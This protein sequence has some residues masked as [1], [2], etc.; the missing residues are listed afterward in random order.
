MTTGFLP[1][2][3]IEV[4]VKDPVPSDG[5]RPSLDGTNQP[6]MTNYAKQTQFTKCPNERK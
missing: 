2:T 4:E 1:T 3:N 5:I 6:I